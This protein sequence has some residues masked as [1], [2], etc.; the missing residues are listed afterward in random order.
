MSV[1]RESISRGD[2][3]EQTHRQLNQLANFWKDTAKIFEPYAYYLSESAKLDNSEKSLT[4]AARLI[5][6]N[7]R[8]ENDV[9]LK[10]WK[11]DL[12]HHLFE[13]AIQ[14]N[15]DNDSL[16]VGLGSCL[17]FWQR[18][19][20]RCGGNHERIQ[21]L[22]TVVRKDS[23]NM[24]AQMV[25]GIGGVISRQYDKAIE[26]LEKVVKHSL[27]TLKHLLAC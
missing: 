4:F 17:C 7:M 5:L 10:I 1:A 26:R 24:Q 6:E 3:H 13:K 25:L 15:P 22:L 12:Q 21:T 9:A 2:V 8:S 11:S 23:N 18:N 20:R 27:V 19:D 16:K 14:L